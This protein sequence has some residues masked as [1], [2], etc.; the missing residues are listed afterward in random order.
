MAGELMQDELISNR[1][2]ENGIDFNRKV[3]HERAL[4]DRLSEG[5]GS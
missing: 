4:G 2:F 3:R 5:A 1:T